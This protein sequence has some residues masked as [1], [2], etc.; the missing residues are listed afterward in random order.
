MLLVAF[1]R[2][3]WRPLLETRS[4]WLA[5]LGASLLAFFVHGVFDSFLSFTSTAMLFWLIV[6]A[7]MA[8]AQF[9]SC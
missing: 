1:G 6:G 3:I 4:V 9:E 2:R 8:A 5:V 7:S